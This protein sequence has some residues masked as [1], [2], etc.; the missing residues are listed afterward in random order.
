MTLPDIVLTLG[1]KEV[2]V[3]IGGKVVFATDGLDNPTRRK[4]APL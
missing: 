2:G 3:G 1:A 4:N